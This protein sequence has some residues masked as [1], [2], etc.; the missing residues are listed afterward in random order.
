MKYDERSQLNPAPPVHTKSVKRYIN[1][2]AIS[3]LN[4]TILVGALLVCEQAV[5]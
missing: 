1:Y 5:N 3:E 4:A 2:S